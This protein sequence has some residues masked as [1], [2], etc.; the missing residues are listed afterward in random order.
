MSAGPLALLRDGASRI[1]AANVSLYRFSKAERNLGGV[2]AEGKKEPFADRDPSDIG[3][4]SMLH[5]R[6]TPAEGYVPGAR[7]S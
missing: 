3:K 4:P 5:P 6:P 1:R 7:A 2:T